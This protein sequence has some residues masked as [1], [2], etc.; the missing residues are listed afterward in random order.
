MARKLTRWDM[1]I[2]DCGKN[3]L[4]RMKSCISLLGIT[5]LSMAACTT[6]E[7]TSPNFP[8]LHGG[9]VGLEAEMEGELVSENGCLRL[10]GIDGT[11]TRTL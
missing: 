10:R 8:Q 1:N 11:D 2:P 6:Q 4:N 9:P 5:L 7:P 3:A